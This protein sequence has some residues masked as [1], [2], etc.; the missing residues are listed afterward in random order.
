[1][2][3]SVSYE[4]GSSSGEAKCNEAADPDENHC[5]NI[6]LKM[7]LSPWTY[8]AVMLQACPEDL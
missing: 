3:S 5:F 2:H 7:L 4:G 8:A 1:M 6:S